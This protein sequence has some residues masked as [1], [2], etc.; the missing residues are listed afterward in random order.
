M[1]CDRCGT[2]VQGRFC[3]NCGKAVEENRDTVQLATRADLPGLPAQPQYQM[4]ASKY[5]SACGHTI[6]TRAEIC[7]HCG[8]RQMAPAHASGEKSKV[9]AGLLAIF[10]G[11]LGIHKF[12]L[13]ETDQGVAFLISS[14]VC[15]FL[16]LIIIGFIGTFI[17]CTIC[18]VQGI[19]YL[20]MSDDAFAA[21]Y[22]SRVLT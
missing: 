10:F 17:I 4:Q 7:P 18:L 20:C 11:P 14:I 1:N 2:Q 22:G 21:K 3:Q 15:G 9:V 16:W 6:D 12:Y 19:M 5:C 8:V 13:G